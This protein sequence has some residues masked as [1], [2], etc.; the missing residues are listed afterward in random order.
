MHVKI[1]IMPID[2]TDAI[3][4]L[5]MPIKKKLVFLVAYS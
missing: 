4:P 3:I 1:I 2:L 5:S